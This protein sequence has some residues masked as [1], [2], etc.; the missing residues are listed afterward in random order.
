MKGVIVG[1]GYW[2]KKLYKHFQD[3]SEIIGYVN[4]GNSEIEGI[5]RISWNNALESDVDFVVLACPIPYLHSYASDALISGKHVFLEKPGAETPEQMEEIKELA[6]KKELIV[7]IGYKF[8]YDKIFQEDIKSFDVL[9]YKNGSFGNNIVLNLASHCFAMA[10]YVL[11][12]IKTTNKVIKENSV[13]AGNKDYYFYI[14]RNSKSKFHKISI[15]GDYWNYFEDNDSLLDKE[16]KH[17]IDCL[18][19]HVENFI[20]PEFALKVLREIA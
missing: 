18:N 5:P 15:N 17:F 8:L 19:G 4:N 20:D 6:Q 9:W 10:L 11:G 1:T 3:H 12:E 14:N 13:S 2:G 7:S 16:V